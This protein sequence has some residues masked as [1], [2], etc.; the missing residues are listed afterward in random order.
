MPAFG[1]ELMEALLASADERRCSLKPAISKPSDVRFP[2]E[3][4]CCVVSMDGEKKGAEPDGCEP[5]CAC[6]E[7]CDWAGDVKVGL[8]CCICGV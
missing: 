4:N 5:K 1:P 3:L 2:D 8:N 6:G 7:Y